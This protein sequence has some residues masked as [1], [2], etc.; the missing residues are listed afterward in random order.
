MTYDLIIVSKSD[1]D[2]IQM[3][4]QCIASSRQ[5]GADINV[6]VVE[7]GNPYK[8]DVDKI[9]EY[10]G[11]FNYNRALNMG[12]KYAKGDVHI[13]ANNDLVFHKGWSQIGNLMKEYGYHSASALSHSCQGFR[14]EDKAYEG[15]DIGT[16]LTGWCIFMDRYC[17]EQIGSLD[18]SVSFWYSD[19]L[20]A[21]QL[22]ASGIAH[23]L[24]CN[25]QVDHITSRTLAKQ[26][27]R[28]QRKFQIGELSKYINRKRYYAQRKRLL[29]VNP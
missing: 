17:H 21:E 12:L 22:Q 25:V 29:G 2:L 26:P 10:N 4:E 13:L 7:T 27:T 11:E 6:I 23:A 18:E 15:Y 28:L 5:D 3:T 20:Y 1:S 16:L 19:N 24:F 9:I 14:Y 8:Y